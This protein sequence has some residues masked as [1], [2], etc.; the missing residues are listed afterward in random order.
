MPHNKRLAAFTIVEILIVAPIVILVIGA[1]I[2]A[3]VS[4]TRDVLASRGSNVLAYN[5]QDALSRI[6]QDVEDSGSFLAFN[7]ITLT[8]S[9]GYNNDTTVFENADKT[10]GAMLI[11]NAYATTNNPL[12][13][14]QNIIYT[15]APNPC[16]G[17][18]VSL[19][20]PLMV[21]IVYFV[22]NNTLWRRVIMPS[23]YTTIGCS[24]PWQ[25]PSCAP[26]ITG[27]NCKAQDIDLVDGVSP[28]GFSVSYYPNPSSIV[29]NGVASDSGQSD[30]NRQTALNSN[31]TVGVTI[32]ASQ[33]IAGRVAS[34]TGSIVAV[35][36]QHFVS[37]YTLT[38]IAS[39]SAGGTISGGGTYT[40]GST[41]NVTA[42]S[43]SYYSFVNWTGD[44]GCSGTV[45]TITITM[46]SNETCTA[47]FTII[48]Y[49]L[50][51][52]AG[53]NGT[54]NTAVNG[55]YSSGSTPTITATPSGGYVFSSWTGS[56]GCSGITTA[57]YAIT[58]D[59]DKTCTANFVVDP[60][61]ANWYSGIAATALAGKFVYKTDLGTTYYYKTTNDAVASPQGAT[62]LDP[63]YPSKMVL[64]SP[65]T[66][67]GVDFSAYPAQNACKAVG[68]R[69]PNMQELN[70]IYVGRTTYGN[71]FQASGYWS[72]TEYVSTY[73]YY[74]VFNGGGTNF[75]NKPNYFFVRCVAG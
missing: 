52:A 73:A 34:Q 65:Q 35:N 58:M 30:V 21:N 44:T 40:A 36:N 62:G 64:V 54:V 63:S 72:S 11:L 19:N 18:Q 38:T 28:S 10:N 60:W 43:N 15:N 66:N 31:N 39:P 51:I 59:G 6:E 50:T 49:T 61:T 32:A 33:T 1:F 45:N 70:A 24:L 26:G 3:I 25:Q 12:S 14:V 48:T 29:A 55:N 8:S 42:T 74:V 53:A 22:R 67:P 17:I 16:G 27:T 46:N 41:P 4:M 47:N 37:S 71:N 9:Q 5:I 75:Y 20:P 13:S 57:S 2:G 56:T 7:N 68:G 23:N 69:L